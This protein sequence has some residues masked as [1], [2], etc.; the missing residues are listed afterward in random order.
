MIYLNQAATSYPKPSGVQEAVQACLKEPPASQF[1]GGISSGGQDGAKACR[2]KL[3]ELLGIAD[4]D[5]IIFTSGA[6]ESLNQLICGLDYQGG[7]ILTTQTEH[8]SVLRPLKNLE[9]TRDLPIKILP[10]TSD[11]T[12]LLE[13]VREYASFGEKVLF[14]NHCSNVTGRVQDLKNITEI[15]HE[16]GIFVIAD[17]SQ[18]AGCVPVHVDE[19]KLDGAAFTGHKSLFGMRGIGGYY[20]RRDIPLV[21]LK[22]GG[23]GRNSSQILYTDDYEYEVG[24][25]NQ[26]GI[27]SLRAGVE[28]ILKEGMDAVEQ[29]EEK[30]MKR[31]AAGLREIPGVTVY[32]RSEDENSVLEA[33]GGWETAAHFPQ[34]NCGWGPVIS[35]CMEGLSPSDTA[36]ILQNSYGIIVRTGLHCAPLI[37]Q[38]LGSEKNGTVRASISYMNEEADIEALLKAVREISRAV[39]GGR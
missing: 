20:L 22:F 2:E 7:R 14:I 23:T 39:S 13:T 5:R 34:S 38:A 18:S 19:W 26:P 35:F 3:G 36:Y 31:L 32:G 17:L 9:K 15:C 4:T 37:H 25:Q 10:C 16:R 24:T 1:R 28:Y 12:I 6:T 27:E 8:N 29:K 33:D 11:G 21:P 30:L